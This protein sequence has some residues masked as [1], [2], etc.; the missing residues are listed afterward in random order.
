MQRLICANSGHCVS[1][2]ESRKADPRLFPVT[3]TSHRLEWEEK[4]EAFATCFAY[5]GTYSVRDNPITHHVLVSSVPKWVNTD[6]V[7]TFKVSPSTLTLTTPP[8]TIGGVVQ[9]TVLNW[10]RTPYTP[11]RQDEYRLRQ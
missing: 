8:M 4:A 1:R 6:L 3:A 2:F 7:R 5:A 11:A 9:S 10:E